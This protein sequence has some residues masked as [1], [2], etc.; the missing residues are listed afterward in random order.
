MLKTSH[1]EGNASLMLHRAPRSLQEPHILAVVAGRLREAALAAAAAP[2]APS[3]RPVDPA[4][5]EQDQALRSQP[6]H[7]LP[8]GLTLGSDRGAM[9][10]A[11]SQRLFLRVIPRRHHVRLTVRGLT[12]RP[13][14]AVE[15]STSS[16]SVASSLDESQEHG[17]V[18]GSNRAARAAAVGPAAM[19]P[20][21]R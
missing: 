16:A 9:L 4:P 18:L 6:R 11:G 12:G 7:Q 15:R 5:V 8:E 17:L 21:A 14:S 10:L 2:L 20:V 13:T 19:P 1:P 3:H